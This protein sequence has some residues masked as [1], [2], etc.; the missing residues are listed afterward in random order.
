VVDCQQQVI[1]QSNNGKVF[2][3]LI[4]KEYLQFCPSKC[5]YKTAGECLTLDQI[6]NDNLDMECRFFHI[7]IKSNTKDKCFFVCEI[8]GQSP[9][10]KQCPFYL[11]PSVRREDYGTT[12]FSGE[13][14]P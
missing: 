6:Y 1:D 5:P 9:T 12:H 4:Y 8:T 11:S 3:C 7:L 10:C 2:F 13:N 14:Q